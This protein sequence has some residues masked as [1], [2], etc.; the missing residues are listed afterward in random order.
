M[1][2]GVRLQTAL[3]G[4]I[5]LR[6]LRMLRRIAIAG[7]V[8]VFFLF[9]AA[10]WVHAKVRSTLGNEGLHWG[11]SLSD[12]LRQRSPNDVGPLSQH[13]ILFNGTRVDVESFTLH[14]N[15]D[16]LIA[17]ILGALRADCGAP[18]QEDASEPL[19]LEE[20]QGL[21]SIGFESTT[22]VFGNVIIEGTEGSEQAVYCFK[23]AHPLH[24]RGIAT[25]ARHFELSRD[26]NDLGAWR[27]IYV[28][29]GQGTAS[30]L[31]LEGHGP[32][33]PE[34]MF[35]QSS[36]APGEDFKE[37]PRPSGRRTLSLAHDGRTALNTYQSATGLAT[38]LGEYQARVKNEGLRV[39]RPA[40]TGTPGNALLVRTRSSSYVVSG[41]ESASGSTLIVAT[42]P[43]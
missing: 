37:L 27:G 21:K 8:S 19:T 5:L 3:S 41:T 40:Q 2:P 4:E 34:I 28:K 30:F 20:E 10:T 17:D 36:D 31:T 11:R 12:S 6:G 25:M 32:F 43:D 26:L 14:G 15:P 42:L 23:P 24:L 13:E 33:K 39:D 22:Q 1:N 9:I 18:R 7:C 16:A 38:A 29:A 35:P